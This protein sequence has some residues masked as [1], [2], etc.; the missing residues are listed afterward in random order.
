MDVQITQIG[1]G[2]IKSAWLAEKKITVPDEA[3]VTVP[4]TVLHLRG[5]LDSSS[6]EVLV[7]AARAEIQRGPRCIVIDLAG[8]EDMSRLSGVVSLYMVGALLEDRNIDDLDGWA[9]LR[10]MCKDFDQGEEFSRLVIAAPNEKVART[11]G[12][13]GFDRLAR[14]SPTVDEAIGSI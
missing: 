1:V 7:E 2:R 8:V 11:L 13:T 10:E 4:I 9:L 3:R 14:V 6:F 5:V 12:I